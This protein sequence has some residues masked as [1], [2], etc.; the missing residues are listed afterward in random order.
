MGEE[1]K[2]LEGTLAEG[3]STIGGNGRVHAMLRSLERRRHGPHEARQAAAEEYVKMQVAAWYAQEYGDKKYVMFTRDL[4]KAA[5]LDTSD[6]ER[7]TQ[8]NLPEYI[9][10]IMKEVPSS[11][12][13]IARDG[14]ASPKG[15]IKVVP[16][17]EA[18]LKVVEEE[19]AERNTPSSGMAV[20]G[21]NGKAYEG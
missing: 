16:Y 3:I 7:L 5:R 11:V 17:L 20:T 2:D 12:K 14:E 8:K 1:D 10:R 21:E 6:M 18:V 9:R 19:N 15:I 4:M 13:K